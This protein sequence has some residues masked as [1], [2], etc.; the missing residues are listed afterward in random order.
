MTHIHIS[1][2]NIA[3]DNMKSFYIPVRDISEEILTELENNNGRMLINMD[4]SGIEFLIKHSNPQTR[5]TEVDKDMI[6]LKS[7][8]FLN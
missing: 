5:Q 6:V 8:K 4:T 3:K 7:L 1:I 2:A